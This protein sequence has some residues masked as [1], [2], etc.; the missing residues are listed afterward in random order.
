MKSIELTDKEISYLLV[1]LGKYEEQLLASDG[2]EMEDA[3]VDLVFAQSLSK[4]LR[5]AKSAS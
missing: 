5:L 2:E 1:A 4:K 3:A